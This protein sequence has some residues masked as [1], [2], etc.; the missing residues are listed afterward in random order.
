MIRRPPRSTLFPYTTLFRSRF[1]VEARLPAA[2]ADPVGLKE[3][4]VVRAN[5]VRGAL[6]ADLDLRSCVDD[7]PAHPKVVERSPNELWEHQDAA[8][9]LRIIH[10]R[11]NRPGHSDTQ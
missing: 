11:R 7:L 4:R 9:L 3:D 6:D 5:G 1:E 10:P 8:R 2:R